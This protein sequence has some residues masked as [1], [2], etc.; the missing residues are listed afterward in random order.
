MLALSDKQKKKAQKKL[1][2]A[3]QAE[4]QPVAKTRTRPRK[5]GGSKQA[6]K[7]GA[8]QD[9]LLDAK[10]DAKPAAKQDAPAQANG[11]AATKPARKPA[12]K[13]AEA[14]AQPEA[15]Q[16]KVPAAKRRAT[17][18]TAPVPSPPETP[19]AAGVLPVRPGRRTISRSLTRHAVRLQ[20]GAKFPTG[21]MP[22]NVASRER[23]VFPRNAGVSRPGEMP[24]P[25]VIV[26]MREDVPAHTRL[27]GR[28]RP[29]SGFLFGCRIAL[30][31]FSPT[32]SARAFHMSNTNPQ[33]SF[34]AWLPSRSRPACSAPCITCAWAVPSS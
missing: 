31:R 10:P 21:G 13:P 25:T 17:H 34:P 15:A 14:T 11:Q 9:A 1:A 3:R 6:V 16:S 7:P 29:A 33:Q 27:P 8:K 20:G 4:A 24:G 28:L 30:K 19:P 12:R 18:K 2:E 22:R 26:R 5:R 32:F 23:P